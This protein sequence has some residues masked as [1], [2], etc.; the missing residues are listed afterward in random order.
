M[1]KLIT[2]F[3]ITLG[4]VCGAS[5]IWFVI[6]ESFGFFDVVIKPITVTW[7][8]FVA[9]LLISLTMYYTKRK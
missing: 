8:T 3:Q 6:S 4:A 9:L 1:K 7:V 5:L 2:K